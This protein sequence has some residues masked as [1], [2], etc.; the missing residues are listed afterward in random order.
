[1]TRVQPHQTRAMI[2][3]S[4]SDCDTRLRGIRRPCYLVAYRLIP[5]FYR[6]QRPPVGD[7]EDAVAG[8][9]V[10]YTDRELV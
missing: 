8:T 10:V 3:L 2:R 7:V 6:M 1:M 9:R 4:E 5:F